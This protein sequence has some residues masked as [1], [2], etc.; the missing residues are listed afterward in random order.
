MSYGHA[1]WIGGRSLGHRLWEAGVTF[2]VGETGDVIARPEI[3]LPAVVPLLAGLGALLA[4]AARGDRGD[5]HAAGRMLALAAATV[6]AP[7]ALALLAPG[8][9][10]I[11]ARNLLPAAVPLLAAVAVGV[12]LRRARRVGIALATVLVAYSLAF[13]IWV[14]ASP[15]LQR[16]D[17]NAVAAKLG[18]PAAPRAMV[19][20]TLGAASLRYYLSTG[21]F[22][23]RPAEGFSWF[24]HEV[25][26]VSDGEA[27]PVRQSLLGPRFRP[28][29]VERAGRLWV[30]RYT[31]PGDDLAHLRLRTI[32]ET[33]LGFR[34][35]GVLLDG[36][37]PG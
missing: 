32:R 21:S 9:D 31:L 3:V 22:Q 1:E 2:A 26:F 25:D 6:V 27:P 8:K 33:D 30:R 19:T 23:V 12:S 35:N 24:V 29:G 4:I 18:E 16:P 14:S 13:S 15:S 10:Y 37:G 36:I 28:A 11:L 7:V 17:W 5:R 34:S 20:W